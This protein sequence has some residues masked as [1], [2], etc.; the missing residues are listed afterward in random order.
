MLLFWQ[1]LIKQSR[2]RVNVPSFN[3]ETV[4]G[5][6]DHGVKLIR[7]L[8]KSSLEVQGALTHAGTCMAPTKGLVN[9]SQVVCRYKLGFRSCT[10]DSGWTCAS[11]DCGRQTLALSVVDELEGGWCQREGVMTRQLPDTAPFELRSDTHLSTSAQYRL[12]CCL[13]MKPAAYEL[14]PCWVFIL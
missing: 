6:C 2:T 1:T 4:T 3:P 14:R 8:M 5:C 7:G 11:G 9:P 13:L 10:D 12:T